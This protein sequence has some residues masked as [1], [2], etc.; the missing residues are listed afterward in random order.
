M[1]GINSALGILNELNG[2]PWAAKLERPQIESILNFL[3]GSA[4]YHYKGWI[5]PALDRNNMDHIKSRKAIPALGLAKN[6]LKNWADSLT[7]AEKAEL[8]QYVSEAEA[9]N[10]TMA[11]QPDGFY[12]GSR[13]FFN[14][15]DMITRRP[16]Y[17]LFVNMASV[18][19]D[20]LESAFPGASGFNFFAADGA[21]FFQKNG[22]EYHKV[23]GA[24]RL[25]AWPGITARA[26]SAA[27]NPIVNWLGYSSRHNFAAGATS[28]SDFAAGFLFEKIDGK[29][30]GKP[31]KDYRKDKNPTIFGVR[32]N[33]GYFLFGNTFLALGSG[34]ANRMND[35]PGNIETSVDQTALD[36]A[37][38]SI[39]AGGLNWQLNNGFAYAVLPDH[40]AGTV[41]VK[42]D[43]RKT[44]WASLCGVNKKVPEK[45]VGVFEMTIDHGKDPK[46]AAYAYVVALDGN[47]ETPIPAILANTPALQAASSADGKTIGALF[48]N[49]KSVLKTPR[50]TV[51]VSSPCALLLEFDDNAGSVKVTVSDAEMNAK[52]A[53]I[54]VLLP[55]K[56]TPV[57]VPMPQEELCGKPASITVS[58]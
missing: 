53:A 19:C 47:P 1:Q 10:I 3:R 55:G 9:C 23:I 7:D 51:R 52:L 54:K 2:T 29:D 49:A 32:A 18:R 37:G 33:K 58:L 44:D 20:G 34:I 42:R 28:G 24:M 35:L 36:P 8:Q 40:T 4:F 56:T 45:T 12:H 48:Y 46:N 38:K 57:S 21:T 16:D 30:K 14:N 11:D 26:Q 15:D 31:A 13:Y 25:S 22:D 5:P 17:Y 39:F 27:Y 6:L 41:S 43:Q 50:G